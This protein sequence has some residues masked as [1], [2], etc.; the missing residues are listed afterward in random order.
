MLPGAVPGAGVVAYAAGGVGV[1][2]LFTGSVLAHELG[3]VLL[4]RRHGVRAEGISLTVLGG[5]TYLPGRLADPSAVWRVAAAGPVVSL[6]LGMVSYALA[7]V[8]D[9]GGATVVGMGATRLAYANFSIGALNLLPGAPFDGGHIL[10]ALLWRGSG[11]RNRA[12]FLAA[13]AGQVLGL[14]LVGAGLLQLVG[15]GWA[16][17][18]T[19]VIGASVLITAT[20]EIGRASTSDVPDAREGMMS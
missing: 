9:S 3:H 18:V 8:A 16:G 15:S 6:V 20:A 19:G 11:D 12:E 10:S 4:A 1:A 17:V 7:L 13:R 2:A 14:M 5:T